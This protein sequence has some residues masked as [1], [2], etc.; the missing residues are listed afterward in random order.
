I[1]L[2]AIF[3]HFILKET[4]T[5]WTS[6][7]ISSMFIGSVQLVSVGIIGEYI[8]RINNNVLDRPLYIIK[9]TNIL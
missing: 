6:L 8:S 2:Y 4:I 5:G 9:E 3:S 1:I 7:I